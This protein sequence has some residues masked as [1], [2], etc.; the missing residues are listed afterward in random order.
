LQGVEPTAQAGPGPTPERSLLKYPIGTTV[1]LAV[2]AQRVFAV[3]LAQLTDSLTAETT[4]QNLRDALDSLWQA[5]AKYGTYRPVAVPVLGARLNPDLSH[6]QII[7][8]IIESFVRNAG[9]SRA[10]AP[11]LRVV[12][13]PGSLGKTDFSHA[14]RLIET[15]SRD[16]QADDR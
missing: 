2:D 12:V 3:V 11:Q 1:P 4:E 13:Q 14:V 7:A 6:G 15:L 5:V 10:A 9:K 8:M 16:P